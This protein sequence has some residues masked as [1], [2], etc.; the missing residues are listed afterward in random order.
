MQKD[1]M[2]LFPR[3][4]LQVADGALRIATQEARGK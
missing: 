1:R 3:R 4:V 2:P